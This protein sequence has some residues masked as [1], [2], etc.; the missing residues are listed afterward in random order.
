MRK[1]FFFSLIVLSSNL[2]L[3]QTSSVK[4]L[5]GKITD[6]IYET[7][8]AAVKIDVF[9]YQTEIKNDLPCLYS[10]KKGIY[11]GV[12]T[13]SALDG[14][15]TLGMPDVKNG[16][17]YFLKISAENYEAVKV[18][19]INFDSNDFINKNIQLVRSVLTYEEELTLKQK[20]DLQLKA[21]AVKRA[22]YEKAEAKQPDNKT[23]NKADTIIHPMPAGGCEYEIPL[24][25]Y[26]DDLQDGYNDCIGGYFT[27]YI[28]FEDYVGGVVQG[29]VGGLGFPTEALKAQAVAARTFSTYKVDVLGFAANCG[30]AYND[31]ISTACSDA[32]E[33]TAGEILLYSGAVAYVRYSARCNGDYTQNYDEYESGCT[34]TY[35]GFYPYLVSVYCSGHVSCEFVAGE[36]FDCCEVYSPDAGDYVHIYGHGVGMCQR[37]IEGFGDAGWSYDDMLTHFYTGVCITSGGGGGTGPDMII[38]E[39]VLSDYSVTCGDEINVDIVGENIGDESMTTPTVCYYFSPDCTIGDGDEFGIGTDEFITLGPGGI[40]FENEDVIIPSGYPNGTY[41]IL[42]LADYTGEFDEIDEDNNVFCASFTYTCGVVVEG[43]DLVV[44]DPELSSTNVNC[45]DEI[46]AS[47][48]IENIGD[49]TMD[50]AEVGFYFSPDCT[51]GDGDDEE[52]DWADLDPIDP[53]D[54]EFSDDSFT[55]P[56]GYAPGSYYIMFVADYNE[57]VD[58]TI[59]TNNIGCVSITYNCIETV[60]DL[61]AEFL[62]VVPATF[63]SGTSVDI[64]IRIT[65][66]GTVMVSP[67]DYEC[68]KTYDDC[69]FDA[70]IDDTTFAG[71]TY[72]LP[73]L[74]PGDYYDKVITTTITGSPGAYFLKVKTDRDDVLTEDNETNNYDCFE[75]TIIEPAT[76]DI[77]IVEISAPVSDCNLSSESITV[78]V[79][80]FGATTVSSFPIKYR[81]NGGPIT[82]E[83]A[84]I[85]LSPGE[86]DDYTFSTEYDFSVAG[87]Y[88]VDAWT[89]LLT[90]ENPANDHWIENVESFATPFIELGPSITVCDATTLNALNPGFDYLWSTGATTQTITVTTSDTYSVT[91]TNPDGG[92]T[93]SDNI[94]V[95]VNHTPIASF[96]HVETGLLVN[97]T[98]TTIY[99]TTYFWE[100]GDGGTSVVTNPNHTYGADGDYVVELTATSICGNDIYTEVISVSDGVSPMADITGDFISVSPTILNAGDL[101]NISY[102]MQNI[103]TGDVVGDFINR[104]KLSPDCSLI[105]ATLFG[106]DSYTNVP[107]AGDEMTIT[108]TDTIPLGTLDGFYS[109]IIAMDAQELI[110]EITDANNNPCYSTIQIVTGTVPYADL[111]STIN[112][113]ASPIYTGTEIDVNVTV[114]NIGTGSSTICDLA[115]YTTEDCFDGTGTFLISESV[116]ALSGGSSNSFTVSVP[117]PAGLIPG[118]HYLK[119]HIDFLSSVTEI[120]EINN[121]DCQL[122]TID[123]G[124]AIANGII[125]NSVQVYPNPAADELIIEFNGNG[126]DANISLLNVIG[127]VIKIASPG[128]SLN[129]DKAIFD[130]SDIAS[131]MYLINIYQPELIYSGKVCIEH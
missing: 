5:S 108:I 50:D 102:T 114:E 31:V 119:T 68:Y 84:L 104:Y 43:P 36:A 7:S 69:I 38:S 121:T 47:C 128:N 58:E 106:F 33:N 131:G 41:Y 40:G 56:E 16:D 52:L 32:A 10:T 120:N 97:F 83:T 105:D 109:I 80:N 6:N 44:N 15:F 117:I 45:G 92:C 70:E 26:V 71:G 39:I 29:E 103:G 87:T 72:A 122:I 63:E 14:S 95:T 65:N 59:E 112:D 34:L 62:S 4:I 60:T 48:Y 82:T 49:E 89:Q 123:E 96:T 88:N 124:T 116:G 64:T 51:W 99:G 91:V 93:D 129:N 46:D 53:G 74:F 76:N 25:V 118:D 77:G 18:T 61:K 27:G 66:V 23:I 35:L 75:Y 107:D 17:Y 19:I 78:S 24:D 79:Q 57:T 13:Y 86:I 54:D 115:F 12:S 127:Q 130:V 73:D 81:V 2:L 55:I 3:S 85:T 8:I 101:I 98:N 111:I 22:D 94:I 11:T 100:F 30:Q 9:K 113:V 1:I 125:S 37:G 67:F 21:D 110:E 90:D 20:K 28:N 42:C 126:K